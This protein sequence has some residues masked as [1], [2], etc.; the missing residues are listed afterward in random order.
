MQILGACVFRR[1][2]NAEARVVYKQVDPFYVRER[3]AHL[4]GVCHVAC[5]AFYARNGAGRAA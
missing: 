2:R 4:F 5:F 1:T 3:R